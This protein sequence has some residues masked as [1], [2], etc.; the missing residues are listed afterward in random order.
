[1]RTEEKEEEE[2]GDRTV[3][4]NNNETSTWCYSTGWINVREFPWVHS[5]LENKGV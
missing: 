1:M 3:T 4:W 5:S 2:G